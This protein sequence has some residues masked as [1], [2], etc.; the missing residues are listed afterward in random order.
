MGK[1]YFAILGVS[2]D[3]PGDEIR[4]AYRRL[5]KEY[6][7]D[8]YSG[9][10]DAFHRIQEAYAVLSNPVRRRA[11]ENRVHRPTPHTAR[12]ADRRDPRPAPEPLVPEPTPVDLGDISPVR[13]FHTVMP[14][15]EE[16]VDWLDADINR[17]IQ[18]R[19]GRV[20][21]LTME[22]RLTREDAF[23]GARARIMVPARTVCP[24]CGGYGGVGTCACARCGGWGV[25]ERDV[26]IAVDAPPGLIR[27]H[28]VMIPLTR[29][30]IRNTRLTVVFRPTATGAL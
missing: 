9:G 7:P 12:P 8:L 23:R 26:P 3:A 6:H 25:L 11:Y 18:S 21:H 22:I 20:E 19:S 29:F 27:D 24:T 16:I 13:S 15:V 5:A 10:S 30:G 17:S 1:S 28:A 14:S 2:A 4:S